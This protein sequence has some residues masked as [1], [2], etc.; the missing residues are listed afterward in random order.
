MENGKT[1]LTNIWVYIAVI[2]LICLG[3]GISL[4]VIN[5]FDT[6]EKQVLALVAYIVACATISWISYLACKLEYV[7]RKK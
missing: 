7:C 5:I 6:I 2:V 4:I 1:Y 3:C